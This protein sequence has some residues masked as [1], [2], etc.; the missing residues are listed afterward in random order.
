MKYWYFKDFTSAI[1]ISDMIPLI[2]L[3]AIKLLAQ[4][5]IF[6]RDSIVKRSNLGKNI[7]K[8]L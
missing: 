8:S 1:L 3:F 4:L 5:N 6:Q 2:L 7:S